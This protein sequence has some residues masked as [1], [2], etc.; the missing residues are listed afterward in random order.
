LKDE[1]TVEIDVTSI[2]PLKLGAHDRAVVW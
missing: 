1:G 2:F